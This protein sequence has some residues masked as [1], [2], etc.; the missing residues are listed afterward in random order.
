[1]AEWVDEG[2][3]GGRTCS[4]KGA[5]CLERE[6]SAERDATGDAGSVPRAAEKDMPLLC[7]ASVCAAADAPN[8]ATMSYMAPLVTV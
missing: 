2:A 7:C 8:F 1:M 3:G 6:R 4:G 5:E